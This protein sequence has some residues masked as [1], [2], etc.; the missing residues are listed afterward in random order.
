MQFTETTYVQLPSDR[1]LI[2]EY[3]IIGGYNYCS[4]TYNNNP[5]SYIYTYTYVYLELT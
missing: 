1:Q 4:A 3:I 2:F 5:F